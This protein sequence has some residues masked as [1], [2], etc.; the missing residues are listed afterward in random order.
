MPSD[1]LVLVRARETAG[2]DSESPSANLHAEETY[3]SSGPSML[4]ELAFSEACRDAHAMPRFN[5]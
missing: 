1:L 2:V 4:L 3:L 5:F